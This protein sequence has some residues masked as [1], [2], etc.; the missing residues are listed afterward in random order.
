[1]KKARLP[2]SLSCPL[3]QT[4]RISHPVPPVLI[5]PSP[6]RAWCRQLPV[7][8]SARLRQPC[9]CPALPQDAPHISPSLRPAPFCS[10]CS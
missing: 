1:M 9:F 4:A 2:P 8:V 10:Q 6:G 5:F 3:L 7:S